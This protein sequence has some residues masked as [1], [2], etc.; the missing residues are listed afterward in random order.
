MVRHAV[1]LNRVSDIIQGQSMSLRM[2][3]ALEWHRS[4]AYFPG[5][6]PAVITRAGPGDCRITSTTHEQL[7]L[8]RVNSHKPPIGSS[9]LS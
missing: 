6:R 3:Y 7:G 4:R 8:I 2:T 9:R 1:G 5:S